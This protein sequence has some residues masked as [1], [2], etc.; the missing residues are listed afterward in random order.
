MDTSH[1]EN[2]DPNRLLILGYLAP[3][4]CL[5]DFSKNHEPYLVIHL[6]T[7]FLR[8]L[9]PARLKLTGDYVKQPPPPPGFHLPNPHG[10]STHCLTS[11]RFEH[12][13]LGGRGKHS[14]SLCQFPN[15][16]LAWLSKFPKISPPLTQTSTLTFHP[17][18]WMIS[19]S[20]IYLFL[21]IHP[22]LHLQKRDGLYKCLQFSLWGCDVSFVKARTIPESRV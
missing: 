21:E 15:E 20:G 22:C 17:P 6:F 12:K 7:M 3:H 19:F 8:P 10:E 11:Q 18:L 16:F 5:T 4:S 9:L 13:E 2:G 14:P 1:W